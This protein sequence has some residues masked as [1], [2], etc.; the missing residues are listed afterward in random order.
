MNNN[1]ANETEWID[2]LSE[3]QNKLS[4]T[5]IEEIIF[6]Y[7]NHWDGKFIHGSWC[8]LYSLFTNQHSS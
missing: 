1:A 2:D 8:H 6:L 4:E 3:I 7:G 5:E